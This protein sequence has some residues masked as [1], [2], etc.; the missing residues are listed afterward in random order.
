MQK[1]YRNHE[2]LGQNQ[3]NEEEVEE[4]VKNYLKRVIITGNPRLPSILQTTRLV[5]RKQ[6]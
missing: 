4:E 5:E 3:E 1:Y 2:T 6:E